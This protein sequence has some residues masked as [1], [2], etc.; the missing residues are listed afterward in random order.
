MSHEPTLE[1]AKDLL[2]RR[3]ITPA[4]A[5]CLDAVADRLAPAGFRTERIDRGGVCNLWARRG[6]GAPLVCIAGHVD[7][8]PPGPLDAWTNDPFTPTERFGRLYARGATDMK[9]A[10]AAAVTAIERF[11]SHYPGHPGSIAVL[12]TSDEE[13]VATDGTVAVVEALHARGESIDY[14]VVT[15]PTSAEQLGDTLKN[16]RRGSLNGTLTVRGVQCH[17]AYP[18]RGRNAIHLA[19]P[20]LADLVAT[21]WDRGNEYFPPTSFQIS[22]VNAGTG[23]VNVAPGALTAL[24]NFRFAPV[25]TVDALQTRTE[26]VLRR[27]GLD[28]A[29]EWT[30]A[31][32]PFLTPHG[33]LVD[34]LT[35]SVR[36]VTG[37][38]PAL[39]TDGGTS[40]ARF[41]AA[42]AREVAEFGPLNAS[43]H[44]VDE[45][46]RLADL[47]PLSLIYEGALERLLRAR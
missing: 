9:G 18:Q 3:S 6:T 10:I 42:I 2:S 21:E 22:N 37:V 44:A 24:F 35:E 41:L 30:V 26:D 38:T 28:Y 11:V 33:A 29:V 12:L 27:H 7:V 31:A 45:H 47:G 36:A 15:E 34:V 20:A 39:S 13:G 19:A 1:L 5:G 4:D 43:A 17:V 16:G 8:V 23:A 40:D 14:C 46:I 25:S 32:M